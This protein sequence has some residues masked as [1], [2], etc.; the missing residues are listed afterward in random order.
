MKDTPK[1]ALPTS[2][3]PPALPPAGKPDV[4]PWDD[5]LADF[6]LPPARVITPHMVLRALRRYWWQILLLWV[7]GSAGMIALIQSQIRPGYEATAWLEVKP[8]SKYALAPTASPTP[9]IDLFMQTQVQLLT[10]PDVLGKAL[11]DPRVVGLSWVRGEVDPRAKLR[12]LLRV[13]IPSKTSLILV[14]ITTPI[15]DDGP[16]I[17]NAVVDAYLAEASSWTDEETRKQLEHLRTLKARYGNDVERYRK[18]LEQLVAKTGNADPNSPLQIE[19]ARYQQYRERLGVIEMERL[20]AE[21]ALTTMRNARRPGGPA[22]A[23]D[24]V[25]PQQFETG[26]QRMF[27]ADPEVANLRH[28]IKRAR[29]ERDHAIRGPRNGAND[30]AVRHHQ[31]RLE[32]LEAEYQQL[33]NERE[34]QIRAQLAAAPAASDPAAEA[35]ATAENRLLKL[36]AEEERI[37]DEVDKIHI[38]SRHEGSDTLK[39]Q[40]VSSELNSSNELYHKVSLMLE[41]HQAETHGPARISRISTARAAQLPNRDHRL[42][43]MAVAPLGL[44]AALV[45]LF[46]LVEARAGRVADPDDLAARL[47]L[48]VIGIVPPLPSLYTPRGTKGL[49]DQRRRVEEFV[50][51]IDHLRVTICAPTRA[52]GG[53]RCVMITS[54]SGGEGKTTLAAQLAGRCA[55]AGLSTVLIDADLRRPALSELLEV[56]QGQGLAEVL[57]GEITPEEA[58]IVIRNA[59]GFHL[60]PAGGGKYDPS[61]LLQGDRLG[62]L[63][64]RLRE[65]FDMVLVDVPPILPVPDALLIGRWADGAVMAVRHDTS[66][67]PLVE[68]AQ[69]RLAGLG[70]PILGAVVNGCR[71][72]AASYGAYGYYGSDGPPSADTVPPV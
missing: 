19:A 45:G 6:D 5:P 4:A 42:A 66:R 53:R 47:R 54:A 69:R 10:S 41:Q 52:G 21:V 64:A 12:D 13:L 60:L 23:A 57:A 1:H 20:E 43:L 58:M 46:V 51:S 59:G 17:V 48:G 38:E 37:R 22:P 50:Q 7:V 62:Q 68:R 8:T 39:A 55:N 18:D 24:Q 44:I 40:F 14:S 56:P 65:A 27:L 35:I 2:W 25:D 15:R 72:S 16:V 33:W 63:I 11:L 71:P 9:D 32:E 3:S 28:D 36:R 26:V 70:I 61:R 34:P 30:P 29:T 49:R 67:L 31:Q